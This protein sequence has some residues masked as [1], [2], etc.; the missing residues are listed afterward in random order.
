VR[1]FAGL[2][3]CPRSE[4]IVSKRSEIF[5]DLASAC[6]TAPKQLARGEAG[7]CNPG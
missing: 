7:S 4:P 1:P 6:R 3:N 2:A 5:P